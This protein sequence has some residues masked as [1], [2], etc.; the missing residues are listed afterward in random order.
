[1]TK[2][3]R[4]IK[5]GLENTKI[6]GEMIASVVGQLSDGA[7]ENSSRLRGY[8]VFAEC[9]SGSSDITVSNSYYDTYYV[10]TNNPYIRMSDMDIRR[11]FANKIKQLVR[12]EL[13]DR[14]EDDIT[15]K[16]FNAHNLPL[17]WRYACP[18]SETDRVIACRADIENFLKNNPF[19]FKGM[20]NANNNEFLNYLSY[21]EN[22]TVGDA[23]KAYQILIK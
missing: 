10:S 11:F 4:T 2:Y 13:K 16:F 15:E 17:E 14:Y 20:F 12:M 5:T 3:T 21:H 6:N 23:Y 9:N 19:S 18:R 22:V 1:M 7:W 8:W